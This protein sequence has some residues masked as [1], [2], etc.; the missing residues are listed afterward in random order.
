MTSLSSSICSLPALR[1]L[2][3]SHNMLTRL[4]DNMDQLASLEYLV[5]IANRLTA[6]P[7]LSRLTRLLGLY[8]SHNQLTAVP[9]HLAGCT[10]LRELYLDHNRLAGAVPASLAVGLTRLTILSLSGNQL[11]CL[12]A[13][14]FISCPRFAFIS[15]EIPDN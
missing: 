3:L 15:I 8:L 13:L 14:P 9:G 1:T 2:D 6:L 10:G 12:P 11:T 7:G 4:P 5:A